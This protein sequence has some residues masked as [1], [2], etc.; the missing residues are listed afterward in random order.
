MQWV[1]LIYLPLSIVGTIFHSQIGDGLPESYTVSVVRELPHTG[2]LFTEGL[3]FSSSG[4]YIVETSGAYPAGTASVVRY[5]DPSTGD[6]IRRYA[7]DGLSAGVFLEGVV[8]IPPTNDVGTALLATPSFSESSQS[9]GRWLV[10][11]Y[12]TGVAYVL[13]DNFNVV[14]SKPYPWNGWGLSLSPDRS[15]FLAT[16]GSEFLMSFDR[17]S[18]ALEDVRPI[19]CLNRPVA[20]INE[21]EMVPNFLGSGRPALLGNLMG[22][23]L[24]LAINPLTARCIGAFH[25][26]NVGE[27]VESKE[28]LGN[29][30][31]NGIAFDPNR[32]SLYVTGK[33]WQKI[34]EV[35]LG[36]RD[37]ETGSGDPVDLSSVDAVGLLQQ[38]LDEAPELPPGAQKVFV[39]GPSAA[40]AR[41]LSRGLF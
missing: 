1:F 34:Y 35:R 20:G 7:Y 2:E 27:I 5:L 23:R 9:V 16:N 25:L 10:T 4:G 26:M 8:E 17:D 3:A 28:S 18:M 30:V 12:D 37:A 19:T 40:S 31:A 11:T 14:S 38:Y 13:D 39:P 21:L 32:Q 29:H 33:N 22:T 24:V 36:R 41:F 6:E 15:R